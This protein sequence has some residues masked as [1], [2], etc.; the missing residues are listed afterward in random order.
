M[1]YVKWAGK[2]DL[3]VSRLGF[4]TTRFNLSDL[5]DDAGIN[6]CAELVLHAVSCGINYF[7]VAPTYSFG[8]AE[9]ILGRAFAQVKTR[10]YVAGKSGLSIDSTAEDIL[11][12]IDCSLKTLG[13]DFLDFYQ[14]WSIMNL[15][16]Y[17]QILQ[18]QGL[19]A[20]VVR[21]KE[22]GYV[23][24]ICA[25]L[26]CTP[27][28]AQ[29]IISD[30]Y[31]EGV[32]ISLNALNYEQWLPVLKLAKDKNVVVSTMNS[33]GGGL[34]PQ[35]PNL[36]RNL[37]STNDGVAVKALRFLA[38]FDELTVILSGMRTVAEIEENLKAFDSPVKS[39][40]NFKLNT[41]DKICSGCN[42]CAPCTVDIPI[43]ACMQAYNYKILVDSDNS[44]TENFM[45]NQ[46]FTRM[47]ANG[48]NFPSL[49]RCIGCRKCEARCTQKIKIAARMHELSNL[50]EKFRYTKSAMQNRLNEVAAELS[51]SKIIGIYPACDYAQRLFEIWDNFELKS[52]CEFFNTSPSLWGKFFLGK[53]IHSPTEIPKLNVDA[54]LI[55]HYAFQNE[56]Y[57]YLNA[58]YPEV[59]LVKLH[60]DGDINWFNVAA[61]K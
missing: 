20:G 37:D 61:N 2:E 39:P 23:K 5:K 38:G 40:A 16:Q 9:K 44:V 15:E 56:I 13:V 50:A 4:G 28:E 59:K 33:L 27:L 47:R 53:P 36:F 51:G 6:R 1:E 35:Y 8:Q 41:A 57:E 12:R 49:K 3:L 14:L 60:K 48:V 55:T 43:S 25:S 42:Y 58:N 11:R 18:P 26:H 17:R 45:A 21:A 34:I 31:F 32:L 7:D 22:K 24:H 19:Y 29:E 46:I 30:G 52:R 10:L 54:I